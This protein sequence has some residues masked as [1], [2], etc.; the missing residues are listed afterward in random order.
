LND[1]KPSVLGALRRVFRQSRTRAA[2]ES[3]YWQRRPE[4]VGPA[5]RSDFGLIGQQ[6]TRQAFE[7]WI[8]AHA[9][10]ETRLLDAGCNT[11]VEGVRLFERGFAGIY[12]G[13]DSNCRALSFALENLAG[14]RA[15]FTLS[16]LARLPFPDRY[17]DIV[18]SKDVIEHASHFEPILGD[19]ARV[20]RSHLV[21]SMFIRPTDA[22]EQIV[23]HRDGYYMN[24]YQRPQLLDFMR[25][26]GFGASET[27]FAQDDDEVL[28]FSHTGSC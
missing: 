23:R 19:L 13:V 21:L 27:V 18:L 3:T 7:D 10:A 11:G 1:P 12:T 15:S 16:D 5:L 9:G 2:D 25:D 20:A 8:V 24:R 6:A 22:A 4:I 17:F 28:A 14:L 26:R